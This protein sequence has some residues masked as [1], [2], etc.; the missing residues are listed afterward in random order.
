MPGPPVAITT[1]VRRWRI[2]SVVPSS[3]TS[4]RHCTSAGGAP[5][6]SAARASTSIVATA[7]RTPRG[8]GAQTT[9]FPDF[10][11]DRALKMTVEVGLVTGTSAATT[12]IGSPMAATREASSRHSTPR[13]RTLR[14]HSAT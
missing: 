13:V 7:H 5:A 9:A 11:A 1:E 2:S 8:C 3:V 6:C 10:T 14:S 12:P 4:S